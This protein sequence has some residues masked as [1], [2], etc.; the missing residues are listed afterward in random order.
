MAWIPKNMDLKQMFYC[1]LYSTTLNMS[2]LIKNLIKSEIRTVI[3][4]LHVNKWNPVK[5]LH[6]MAEVCGKNMKLNSKVQKWC[7]G[8]VHI[9]MKKT[10]VADLHLSLISSCSVMITSVFWWVSLCKQRFYS[11]SVKH[12]GG[13]SIR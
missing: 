8:G 2:T 12:S 9:L 5:I 11:E 13:L 7:W 6:Q 1:A 3:E 10:I 4:F